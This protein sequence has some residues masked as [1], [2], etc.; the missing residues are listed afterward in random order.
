MKITDYLYPSKAAEL[1]PDY[2]E[3][4]MI[5]VIHVTIQ[6]EV[7]KKKKFDRRIVDGIFIKVSRKPGVQIFILEPTKNDLRNSRFTLNESTQLTLTVHGWIY[8]SIK[9]IFSSKPS[10][11]IVYAK[12]IGYD[13][14]SDSATIS[15][16]KMR[17]KDRR[18]ILD[19]DSKH[20]FK[21]RD[22]YYDDCAKKLHDETGYK[23]GEIW[24]PNY[25]PLKRIP[26]HMKNMEGYQKLKK[27][28]IFSILED[29]V[30]TSDF[31]VISTIGFLETYNYFNRKR[32]IPKK[33]FCFFDGSYEY[34]IL[35]IKYL[36]RP[37]YPILVIGRLDSKLTDK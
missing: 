1:L 23:I 34:E 4:D 17:Y 15:F 25:N 22:G 14:P 13:V 12:L 3:N 19:F 28:S 26:V 37:N 20:V 30:D 5:P 6:N 2:S 24:N 21:F 33:G 36:E 7:I 29:N 31:K 32:V 16:D 18:A 35:D 10:H 9:I 27:K 11:P 8:Q